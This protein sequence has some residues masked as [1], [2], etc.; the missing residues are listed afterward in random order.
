MDIYKEQGFV[1]RNDYLEHLADDN[2]YPIDA[3]RV[4]AL[5]LGPSEDFD[6]LITTLEDAADAGDFV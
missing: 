1:D 5:I 6:G 2:G 4:L 3:V